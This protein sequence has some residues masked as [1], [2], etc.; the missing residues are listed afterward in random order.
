[1]MSSAVMLSSTCMAKHA[2][3]YS[4]TSALASTCAGPAAAMTK[5]QVRR[6]CLYP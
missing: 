1:M 5:A 3:L 4:S 2:L 6:W